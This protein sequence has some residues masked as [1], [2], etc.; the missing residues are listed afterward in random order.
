M[1]KSMI[2]GTFLPMLLLV[3]FATAMGIPPQ[4]I[5][6]HRPAFE[7]ASVREIPPGTRRQPGMKIDGAR[8]ECQLRLIDLIA[9]A[10]RLKTPLQIVGPDWLDSER[11]EIHAKMPEGATKDQVP[12]MLQ[13]LLADRF[14]LAVHR[15]KRNQP[16]YALVVAKGGPKLQKAVETD[17]PPTSP[18]LNAG[19]STSQMTLYTR[20]G[21]QITIRQEGRGTSVRTGGSVGTV[22]TSTGPNRTM[23]MEL[24]KVT[25]DA[26]AEETLAGMVPDRP[27][28]NQ[29]RLKGFYQ[30]TL[31]L[32]FE[33]L[34]SDMMR[35]LPQNPALG[36]VSTPFGSPAAPAP[37]TDG[38]SDPSSGVVFRAVQ[39]LGLKLESRKASV[40]KL[41]IDRIEKN[42]TEN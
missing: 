1:K 34:M 6:D 8:V 37:A 25:M 11:I 9:T 36:S 5:A 20:D 30:V 27:V 38:A 13:S 24:P 23:R 10:Y 35:S 31:E 15:E 39:K 4:I 17:A 32:P 41:I 7:V 40:E 33:A 26:F 12:Q 21:Q 3:I 19:G 22:R 18:E 29:T 28:V 14:K 2:Y 16:V 42:P